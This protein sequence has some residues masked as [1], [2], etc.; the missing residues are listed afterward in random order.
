MDLKS[1]R[2]SY[3][4]F[5]RQDLSLF[6]SVFSNEQVM[7]YAW[8]DKFNNEEDI[9]PFFEDFINKDDTP[10][11]NN[12]YAFAMFSRENDAFI[13]FADIV[14]QSQNPFGG[15]GEIGYFL[16]PEYWGKGYATELANTLLEVGF[17][18]L[19]LHKMCARCDSN[20]LKSEGIM[21]KTGMTKE[22][23]LRK[24]RFKYGQWEDEKHYGILLDEWKAKQDTKK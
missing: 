8:I 3:R 7:R 11:K 13:G 9:I 22:G 1:E 4:Y 18:K 21:K 23:E 5:T 24:V 20:N 2:L 16:L 6:Y 19:R 12:S 15:C 17:T 10:N 14:L